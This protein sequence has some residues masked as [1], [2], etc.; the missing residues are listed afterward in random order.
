MS[1]TTIPKFR[2]A[3]RLI[4]WMERNWHCFIQEGQATRLPPDREAV[5]LKTKKE[6]PQEVAACIARYAG[7]AGRLDPQY[8]NILRPFKD[9][10]FAYLRALHNKEVEIPQ[11]LLDE[12]AGDSKN[13]YRWAKVTDAR[14]QAHLEDTICEPKFAFL[15]A[16]EVLRGRLPSHLEEVFFK[17][18]YYASKYAFDV[19]RGFASVRL[20]EALHN[21]MIMKSYEDPSNENIRTYV[22]A[23]END[24]SRVGNY[25]EKPD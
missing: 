14:L 10:L 16:K 25:D 4:H 2:S 1:T 15:Y 13:L 17:D 11:D 8:E 22:R 6:Q 18:V 7:W 12:L 5:F 9:S 24:P 3:K 20:P 21:M 19:I 23:A